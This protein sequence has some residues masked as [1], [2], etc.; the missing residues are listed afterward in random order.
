MDVK[1][2]SDTVVM[3]TQQKKPFKSLG[4]MTKKAT[5]IA[6]GMSTP[7]KIGGINTTGTTFASIKSTVTG[8]KIDIPDTSSPIMDSKCKELDQSAAFMEAVLK[9]MKK[10]Q[11]QLKQYLE[12]GED[13]QQA[14]TIYAGYV[15]SSCSADDLGTALELVAKFEGVYKM[16]L[17]D[18]HTHIGKVYEE[19]NQWIQNSVPVAQGEKKKFELARKALDS[20]NTKLLLL[21]Q[22]E[23]KVNKENKVKLQKRTFAMNLQT[24][25]DRDQCPNNMIPFLDNCFTYL[26]QRGLTT[27]GLFRVSPPKPSLDTI[28]EKIDKGADVDMMEID[29]VHMV[30]GLIK[31]FL[32]E[33]PSP[34]L[35]FELYQQWMTITTLKSAQEQIVGIK[36]TIEQL[37]PAN[38]VLLERLLRLCTKILLYEEQNKMTVENLA[39]VLCPSILYDRNPEPV[40]MVQDIQ[41]GN[42]LWY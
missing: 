31:L 36:Q 7:G 8:E 18:L 13:L 19:I 29:E 33:M 3:K 16:M 1:K 9:G 35:T 28:R 30:S 39:I 10:Q 14:L 37:P 11:K 4:S 15:R 25:C 42:K 38:K 26:E 22:Q 24:V 2:K 12:S 32:R 23:N 34:L 27:T 17:N 5:K 21:Q 20:T 40:T 6:K 41:R